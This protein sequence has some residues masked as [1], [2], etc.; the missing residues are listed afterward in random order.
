MQKSL[1]QKFIR[2][3]KSSCCFALSLYVCIWKPFWKQW[4]FVFESA[5]FHPSVC[6]MYKVW[7]WK[8]ISPAPPLGWCLILTGTL[9]CTFASYNVRFCPV[10]HPYTKVAYNTK[11]HLS[12]KKWSLNS[13]T[14]HGI[15]RRRPALC[16]S[17]LHNGGLLH[18]PNASVCI[19]DGTAARAT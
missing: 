10:R 3:W 7:F 17:A 4:F 6:S 12:K 8:V 5:I 15:F 9:W 16:I 14:V 11:P 1:N 19:L 2:N 13:G 18:A